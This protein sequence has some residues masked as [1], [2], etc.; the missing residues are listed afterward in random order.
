M[1]DKT[2]K[3]LFFVFYAFLFAFLIFF[4]NNSKKST[5]NIIDTTD[6]NV[7][8]IKNYGFSHIINDSIELDGK[9]YGLKEL[10]TKK[11][12]GVETVFY[13]EDNNLYI[14]EGE[15]FKKYNG[16]I[17]EGIDTDLLDMLYVHEILKDEKTNEIK[18]KTDNTVTVYNVKY[19][20]TVTM[21]YDDNQDWYKMVIN[22]DDYK[23]ETRY[24]DSEKIKDFDVTKK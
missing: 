5:S 17:V 23:I 20:M 11:E 14:K 6:K 4:I 9:V 16:K 12:N 21:Y 3:I 22:K 8:I 13:K 19:K 15:E 1:K 7:K 10:I 18:E 2:K 24:F